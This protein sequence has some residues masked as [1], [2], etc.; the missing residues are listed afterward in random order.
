MTKTIRTIL[1]LCLCFLGSACASSLVVDS[2][3]DK[4]DLD[5]NDGVCK[6]EDNDCTLRAAI[7]EANLSDDVSKITFKNVT[8]IA[9]ISPLPELTA[10]NTHID[11]DGVVFLRGIHITEGSTSGIKIKDSS[12]NII[13]GLLIREFWYGITILSHQGSA[14]N[15]TIGLTASDQGNPS[16]RNSI[17]LNK[18][19]IH[20]LGIN[21]SN[22]RISGNYIGMKQNV[23]EIKPNESSGI[24][25]SGKAHDNL[26]GSVSGSGVGAGGNLISANSAQG[27][28]ISEGFQNHITGNY[29]GTDESGTSAKGNVVGIRINNGS[30]NNIIGINPSGE[31]SLNLISG[32]L[33][34]GIYIADQDSYTNIIAGNLIGTNFDGSGPL[35]NGASGISTSGDSTRIGTNGDGAFDQIESNLI[36][37][38]GTIGIHI[39]SNGNQVSGNRI[40]VDSTGLIGIGNTYNGIMIDGYDNLIGTNGDGIADEDERNIISA[41]A[42]GF[43]GS[44]GVG[45]R[46]N[47]NTVAGNYI[48]TDITGSAALGNLEDGIG[49]SDGAMNNLIGTDGD[50][51]ADDKEGNLISANGRSGITLYDSEQNTIAGN[52]IGT[53]AAGTAAL[54]NGTNN[55]S[56]LGAVHLG[57]GSVQNVIG[58][59]G[60]GKNDPAEGNII[61]GNSQVGIKLVG[62]N[63]HANEL[64]GN[65]IG[66]GINASAV[67][68]NQ[69]GIVLG[70]DAD[71]NLIGTDAD[72]NS[73][74]HEGN[75]IGGNSGEGIS[76]S[77]SNNQIS[78]NFIGTDKLGTAD[79]GNGSPGISITDNT[80]DNTIGG[81]NQKANTIAFNKNVGVVVAGMNANNVQILNNSIHSNDRNGISL[82]APGSS[83]P[84]FT[85][86]DPGDVDLGPNDL[87]NFPDLNKASSTPGT[88]SI[89]GQITNGLPGTSFLI[90]FFANDIC[91]PYS[92]HGEG[93]TYI[94]S[95]T[96][97]TDSNGNA[98]FNTSFGGVVSAGKFITATATTANK[99][100]EFSNCVEVTEGQVTYS[101]ELEDKPCGQLNREELTLTTFG[102]RP[103]SGL[104]I[105]YLKN[106]APYPGFEAD[107]E[108]EYSA[109]VGDVKASSCYFLDFEDRV[110][111]DFYIPESYFNSTQVLQAFSSTCFPPFYINQEVSI[112]TKLPSGPASGDPGGPSGEP[113]GCHSGLDQRSCIAAGGTYSSG[114]CICPRR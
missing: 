58:T 9:P 101:Q 70:N 52:L 19:G 82:D 92:N 109:M 85:P 36:S 107:D 32:N 43:N 50:G 97:L 95:I 64:A 114:S 45:I 18:V 99:T 38:N 17:I 68:G 65:Y 41:N 37:G 4:P 44:E 91:D 54:P 51:T 87:M 25:I 102:V 21:T 16:K 63:T 59:N 15:N 113:G 28:L 77:G 72:G 57:A 47:S 71:Y 93:K 67:L 86:N 79:L 73:D 60:D 90:Q 7:M 55:S 12:H 62:P 35:G 74:L 111:C 110:Y 106:T 80:T 5:L 24:Y 48:G 98:A 23:S 22:N 69:R 81:S 105:V 8:E 96:Q 83:G 39:H 76:V 94:S 20:L 84:F 3:G 11:G 26:I 6:T 46:G 1:V 88:V 78:G 33:E 108:Q 10:S 34:H 89:S 112:F 27:I 103:E 30:K 42:T 100:S 40:G 53:D 49:I 2:A 31:G 75:V 66:V 14:T 104:F 13:Q 61:S 56:G 29:I